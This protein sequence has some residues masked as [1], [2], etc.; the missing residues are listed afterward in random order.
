M[1]LVTFT[2][3]KPLCLPA[4]HFYKKNW[5]S[6]SRGLRLSI[7]SFY[8]PPSK[9]CLSLLSLLI[10]PLPLPLCTISTVFL[11]VTLTRLINIGALPFYL[12]Y[13]NDLCR[14][15]CSIT[16]KRHHDHG[17]AYKR[18]HFTRGGLQCQRF[19]LLS[20]QGTW[21]HAGRQND[22][23]G[24]FY[25]QTHHIHRQQEESN[26]GSGLGFWN[27]RAHPQWHTPSNKGTRTPT[28][29]RLLILLK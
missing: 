8:Y 17:I 7:V 1:Q 6:K 22:G 25:I 10:S 13:S 23:E 9:R 14:S 16:V 20:L 18:K 26:T 27:P 21:Q 3:S 15:F 11:Q 12:Y 29:P 2:N 4:Y 5:L 19:S 24:E 28:R